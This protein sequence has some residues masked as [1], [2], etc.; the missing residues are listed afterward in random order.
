MTHKW[1]LI[2]KTNKQEKYKNIKNKLIVT[3]GEGE[4]DNGGKP[5]TGCQGTYIKDT[6]T[7]P[8]A[9]KIEYGRWG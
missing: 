8:K 7:K 3:R 6:W 9:G 4:G 2:N 1:K 5:G